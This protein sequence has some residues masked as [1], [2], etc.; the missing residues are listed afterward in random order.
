[1][2]AADWMKDGTCQSY[3]YVPEIEGCSNEAE[4]NCPG[5][6]KKESNQLIE[7]EQQLH[8]LR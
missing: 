5:D 8:K 6:K 7:S 2:E 4:V 1:M 3:F